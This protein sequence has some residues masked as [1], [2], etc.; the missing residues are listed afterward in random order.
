MAGRLP[1][2]SPGTTQCDLLRQF[3]VGEV[4]PQN[5]RRKIENPQT[6]PTTVLASGA[7]CAGR[8]RCG[9]RCAGRGRCGTRC[10]GRCGTGCREGEVWNSVCRE[11]EVWNSVCREGE[12]W[13]SVCRE[14]EV[15]N[16]VCREVWHRPG[17]PVGQGWHSAHLVGPPPSFLWQF[18]Q[19][20]CMASLKDGA[21]PLVFLWQSKQAVPEPLW[22][23]FLQ[24]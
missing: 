22:W 16:S 21:S 17:R 9:T 4:C 20:L 13:N 11:G 24:L 18:L 10:A 2:A 19:L 7:R 1:G 3:P 15:W 6:D 8:G 14:G 23:H 12:V 5:R